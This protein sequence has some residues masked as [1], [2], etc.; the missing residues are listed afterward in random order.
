MEGPSSYDQAN[1]RSI[2]FADYDGTETGFSS[3]W[4]QGVQLCERD[5][6]TEPVGTAD[7]EAQTQKR[8]LDAADAGTDAAWDGLGTA[9]AEVQTDDQSP[10][11]AAAMAQLG[12]GGDEGALT[13]FLQRVAPGV[14]AQ[15]DRNLRETVLNGYDVNWGADDAALSCVH[16]LRFKGAKQAFIDE[17][18]ASALSG[19]SEDAP[20]LPVSSISWN[21][22]G[23]VVAVGYGGCQQGVGWSDQPASIAVWNLARPLVNKEKPDHVLSVPSCVTGLA[24]HP[25]KPAIITAGTLSGQIFVWDL[26]LEGDET[27]VGESVASSDKAH[28]EPIASVSWVYNIREQSHEILSTAPD[29]MVLLWQIKKMDAPHKRYTL[30]PDASALRVQPKLNRERPLGATTLALSKVEAGTFVVGTESGGVHRCFLHAAPGG[31]AAAGATIDRSPVVASYEPHSGVVHDLDFS[32]HHRNL[33]ASTASDGALRLYNM[34]QAAPL[35]RLEPAAAGL[36]RVRWSKLRPTRLVAAGLD[37]ALY[38]FDLHES[39]QTAQQV[40]RP[41]EAAGRAGAL[42]QLC[43]LE[44]SAEHEFLATGDSDGVVRVYGGGGE[45]S[46]GV[47]DTK[48]QL[49]AL[50]RLVVT[51]AEE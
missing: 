37:G 45:G 2:Y 40:V 51:D 50:E 6:Q 43:A 39:K 25:E 33:F 9:E 29:G 13:Q 10:S 21:S 20:S 31:G 1:L 44:I 16:E 7:S 47:Q 15:L 24:F 26:T 8:K 5:A 27:L 34:L 19:E 14:E 42:P 22:T 49:E 12:Q 23:W 35:L 11:M 32:A 30:L 18:G 28:K 36:S 3:L 4:R 46:I 38:I 17:A 48:S 41:P